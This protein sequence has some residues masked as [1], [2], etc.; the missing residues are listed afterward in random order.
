MSLRV[1]RPLR[2]RLLLIRPLTVLAVTLVAGAPAVAQTAPKI[3]AADYDRAVRFLRPNVDPLVIGGEVV[4][5]WLPDGRFWY[6]SEVVGGHEFVMVNPARKSRA[7]AFD[8][9][10]EGNR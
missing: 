5:H 6:R 9:A 3:T 7:S 4:A 1:R 10:G 2:R 8:P